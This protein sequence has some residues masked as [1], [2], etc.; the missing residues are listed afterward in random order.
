MRRS[1]PASVRFTD[2][3]GF[4]EHEDLSPDNVG[5]SNAEQPHRHQAF[6]TQREV[7][8]TPGEGGRAVGSRHLAS[9]MAGTTALTLPK[10]AIRA[11]VARIGTP[12]PSDTALV[13]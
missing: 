7:T 13:C 11:T 3:L 9:T 4:R 12:S 10:C 5:C 6:G 2:R 8:G 1:D